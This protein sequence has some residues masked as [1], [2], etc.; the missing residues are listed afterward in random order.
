MTNPVDLEAVALDVARAEMGVEVQLQ[1]VAANALDLRALVVFGGASTV[2]GIAA[3]LVEPLTGLAAILAGAAAVVALAGM[4]VAVLAFVPRV[5]TMVSP[6]A[7]KRLDPDQT[8]AGLHARALARRAE[9]YYRNGNLLRTK[10]ERVRSGFTMAV[11]AVP[12]LIIAG[13]LGWS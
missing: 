4:A 12:L 7:Y 10:A 11:T 8:V 9:D 2:G 13:L 5:E 3:R 6:S 1:A